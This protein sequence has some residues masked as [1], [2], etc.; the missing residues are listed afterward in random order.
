MEWKFSKRNVSLQRGIEMMNAHVDA[1]IDGQAD[2]LVWFLQHPSLYTSGLHSTRIGN[3]TQAKLPA[4]SYNADRLGQMTYHGPGQRVVYMMINLIKRQINL[5]D[6]IT[7]MN[8]SIVNAL[9]SLNIFADIR[10]GARA[11][12]WIPGANGYEKK[13]GFVGPRARKGITYHGM[14]INVNCDLSYFDHIEPCGVKDDKYSVTAINQID[15]TITIEQLDAA[16][17]RAIEEIYK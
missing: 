16:L 4:K 8:Q 7:M 15:D 5:E 9:S 1:M 17:Q 13:I 3:A 10:I 14:S 11:G 12:V 6:H 2:E